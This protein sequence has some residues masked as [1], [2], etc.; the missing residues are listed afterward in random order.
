MRIE[1]SRLAM[2][3]LAAF[4]AA[5]GPA[6]ADSVADFYQGRTINYFLATTAGG[7]WDVYLRVL[8]NHWTRHIPGHPTM[9]LQYQPGGGVKTLEI[10]VRHRAEGRHRD[11]DP[12]ADLAHLFR[13]QSAQREL[14]AATLPGGSATWRAPRT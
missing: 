7:S 2:L 5:A 9:V 14:P 6:S 10:H 11:R 12:A 13:A 4:T 1:P 3:A 8:I